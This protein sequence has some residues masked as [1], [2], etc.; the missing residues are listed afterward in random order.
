MTRGALAA[1]SGD[2]ER[3]IADFERGRDTYTDVG[4]HSGQP[5]FAASLAMNL[6]VHGATAEAARYVAEARAVLDERG[7]QWNAPIVL[8]AEGVL[9]DELG[10]R[11]GAAAWL[12]AAIAVA[13][14]QGSSRSSTASPGSHPTAASRSTMPAPACD[15]RSSRSWSRT[16]TTSPASLP[17]AFR[18]AAF[19]GSMCVPS[20]RAMNDARNGTPSIV[21]RTFTS[22]RVPK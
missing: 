3:A 19:T 5:M 16:V 4:G 17:I 9:A 13:R 14:E 2:L 15:Q 1:L 8:L 20:P 10:D 12:A 22:P 6:A 7:E 18:T 11:P 21:P